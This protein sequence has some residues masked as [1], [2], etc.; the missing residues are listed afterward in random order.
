MH[1]QIKSYSVIL[2]T[3]DNLK[4]T[5]CTATVWMTSDSIHYLAVE[6]GPTD[7][8]REGPLQGTV[9]TVILGP[10]LHGTV[11]FGLALLGPELLGP[12]R[13]ELD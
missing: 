7:G 9:T 5:L 2:F 10:V 8:D 13:L 1:D 11:L 3:V 4:C 12:A 6:G